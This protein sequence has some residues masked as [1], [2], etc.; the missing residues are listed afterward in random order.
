MARVRVASGSDRETLGA[1]RR[2]AGSLNELA[3]APQTRRRYAQAARSFFLWASEAGIQW[4][5]SIHALSDAVAGYLEY[6]WSE[7]HPKGQA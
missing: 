3:I 6:L 5:Q 2:T 4:E 1:L 7:G